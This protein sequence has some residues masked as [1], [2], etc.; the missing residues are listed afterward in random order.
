[1]SL[2]FKGQDSTF[3]LREL[4]L[5]DASRL[6]SWVR[7]LE[8]VGKSS[9]QISQLIAAC[10]VRSFF[11]HESRRSQLSLVEVFHTRNL[12]DLPACHQ[13]RWVSSV[14]GAFA[15]AQTRVLA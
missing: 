8:T 15:P 12:G 11:S 9:E 13:D 10:L 14:D 3:D 7:D 4:S 1:M 6:G 2:S 5:G